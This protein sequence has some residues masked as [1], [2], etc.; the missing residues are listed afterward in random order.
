VGYSHY[1]YQS[2]ALADDEWSRLQEEAQKIFR[3]SEVPLA[4]GAGD[5]GTHPVINADE[6]L[7]NGVEE[8]SYETCI[9]TREQGDYRFNSTPGSSFESVKTNGRPY[10]KVV[11]AVY[12]AMKTIAP[13]AYTL[14][15]DG[16]HQVFGDI[17]EDTP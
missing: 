17:E 9:I 2:R 12:R 15:S 4:D 8:D 1:Y 7:F 14:S 5:V 11:V 6:I 10:D 13:D 3:E 16:G